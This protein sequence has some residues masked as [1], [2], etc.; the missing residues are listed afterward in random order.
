MSFTE[1]MSDKSPILLPSKL[2][3]G[4]Q[5]QPQNCGDK[6]QGEGKQGL[7]GTVMLWLCKGAALYLNSIIWKKK[8]TKTTIK[9]TLLF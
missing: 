9:T 3:G 4:C 8:K 5:P 1:S 7:A 2:G 6:S